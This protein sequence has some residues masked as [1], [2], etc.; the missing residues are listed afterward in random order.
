MDMGLQPGRLCFLDRFTWMFNSSSLACPT[1]NSLVFPNILHSILS[2]PQTKSRGQSL[3]PFFV[4]YSHR[5]AS[6]TPVVSAFTIHP[7]S[8]LP[9]LNPSTTTTL[10]Q[11][12][13]RPGQFYYMSLITGFSSLTHLVS[14]TD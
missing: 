1:L 8:Y 11:A 9:L 2:A 4:S 12:T 3:N 10:I 6:T 5:N 13:T 14:V 7:D